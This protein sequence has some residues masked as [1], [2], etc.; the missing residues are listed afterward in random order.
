MGLLLSSRIILTFSREREEKNEN[1]FLLYFII[2]YF[3]TSHLILHCERQ[4]QV[5]Y[6]NLKFTEAKNISISVSFHWIVSS[7]SL[8]ETRYFTAFDVSLSSLFNLFRMATTLPRIICLR[9]SKIEIHISFH[10]KSPELESWQRRGWYFSR[11]DRA[12]NEWLG[13]IRAATRIN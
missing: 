4:T 10:Y 7:L 6:I 9:T 5:Q 12:S 11:A 2:L 8:T 13:P 1:M 3:I